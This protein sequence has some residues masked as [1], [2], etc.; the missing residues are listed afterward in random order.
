MQLT[1]HK[2]RSFDREETV[3]ERHGAASANAVVSGVRRSSVRPIITVTAGLKRATRGRFALATAPLSVD[4]P[5]RSPRDSGA[6][7]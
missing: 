6:T 4:R 3:D 1:G 5:D 2:T 7:L